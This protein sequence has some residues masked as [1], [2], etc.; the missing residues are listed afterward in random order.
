MKLQSNRLAASKR[1]EEG[2]ADIPVRSKVTNQAGIS[3]SNAE[4][5]SPSP[6][7]WDLSRLGSG[8]R[9]ACRES[10]NSSLGNTSQERELHSTEGEGPR[11]PSERE[12]AS[13]WAG[14][15]AEVFF[16][17]ILMAVCFCCATSSRAATPADFAQWQQLITDTTKALRNNQLPEAIHLCEQALALSTNFGPTNTA[18]ART[19]VLR[20]EVYLWENKK[21]LAELT[22][23]QAVA[24][25]E[26]A[27]GTNSVEV[28]HPLSSLANYYYFVVKQYDQ[29]I[30]I[31]ERILTIVD[32]DKNR[33]D[34]DIIM[35]SRNL[36]MIYQQTGQYAKGEPMFKR[37]VTLAERDSEWFPHELL[38]AAEFYR[39]WGKYA[40]AE[41]L[42]Q[43]AL[44]IREK[45]L[46]ANNPDSQLD[47][48]VC[49]NGL[50]AIY[51]SWNKPDKAESTY[52]RSLA[53]VQKFM[54][55][56]EADL[57]P[58]LQ[59]LASALAAERQFEQAAP[60][61][62]RALAIAEKNS[63]PND[64]QV[65]TLLGNYAAVLKEMGKAEDAKKVQDR[66]DNILKQTARTE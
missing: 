12:R 50:G 34:R 63:G 51:L 6:I 5:T 42:A 65:A 57:S 48:A 52:R 13:H 7:G 36:G 35:W 31:F 62:Q 58:A 45:V 44:A 22:F 54:G 1:S 25:C 64:P 59:G 8:E 32:A 39:A 30:P 56:E 41:T 4:A 60:L 43:H 26:K 37:A 16:S 11:G 2:T 19:Q 15:R 47:T 27:A 14:V 23:K 3:C 20:A 55:P 49:L 53:M 38:N 10:D 18:Y 17:A 21:D 66:A 24:S 46:V 29:V 61:Y 9:F 28:I 33:T 40:Q